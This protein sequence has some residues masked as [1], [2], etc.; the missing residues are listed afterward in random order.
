MKDSQIDISSSQPIIDGSRFNQQS[1]ISE[2][3]VFESNPVSSSS[4]SSSSSSVIPDFRIQ[5]SENIN[6]TLNSLSEIILSADSKSEFIQILKENPDNNS[7]V[8]F[9]NLVKNG[10]IEKK[11]TREFLFS[12]LLRKLNFEYPFTFNLPLHRFFSLLLNRLVSFNCNEL[13]LLDEINSVDLLL[14]SQ[15]P[16]FLLMY[17]AK[18]SSGFSFYFIIFLY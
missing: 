5:Y 12:F 2:I 1:V 17:F 15:Q 6:T 7:T 13:K 8:D 11:K 3:P 14:I 10:I 16:L 4:S 9:E 18:A